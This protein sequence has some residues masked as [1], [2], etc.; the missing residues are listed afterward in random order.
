[1]KRI[2]TLLV[3]T[4]QAV[5]VIAQACNALDPNF[6]SGGVQVGIT[7]SDWLDPRNIVV[8]P[9][10]KIVQFGSLYSNGAHFSIVRYNSD[11]SLDNSFGQNGRVL[12]SMSQ[13]DVASFGAVQNDGKILVVGTVQYGGV[14]LA[15]YNHDGTPDNNFGSAGAVI[16]AGHD[17]DFA[18]GLAIQSDGKIVVV[19]STT[20]TDDCMTGNWGN[21]FCPNHFTVFRLKIDGSIDSSFGENGKVI[22]AVGPNHAGYASSV[23][24]QTD[25]KI[26]VAGS[27]LYNLLYDDYYGT[28][29]F[30]SSH[31]VMV[32]YNN[33]GVLDSSFGANGFV[34][35]ASEFQS[36]TAISLQADGKVLVTGWGGRPFEIERY[37]SDGSPDNSFG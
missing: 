5:H 8:Q 20:R 12:S 9:D 21:Q 34:A 28:Y 31:L 23:A 10:N 25:G 16:I 18:R 33:D 22:T 4:S 35:D 32:R 29:Y 15:R 2:L 36:A 24:I 13:Y 14:A 37:S 27:Y 1:M 11:G 30:A 7:T 3:L 17:G 6:G 26:V 19:G